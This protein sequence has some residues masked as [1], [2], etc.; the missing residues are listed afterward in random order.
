[1]S[2]QA[3]A[4]LRT[5]VMTASP[6]ELRLMLLDGAIKFAQ[7]GREG[8]ATKNYEMSFNGIDRCRNII[9]ELIVTV[10]DDV[11]PD[12][13]KNVKS[14]YTF[15][16]NELTNA[17]LEKDVSKIDKVIELLNFERETWVMLMDQLTKERAAGLVPE[18]V[19]ASAPRENAPIARGEPISFQA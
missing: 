9:L 13:A 1:M 6:E 7:Q 5:R 18:A 10:R 11:A 4:Y 19:P 16:Y 8:L 14:L 17:S 2:D 15:F 12:L 3:N